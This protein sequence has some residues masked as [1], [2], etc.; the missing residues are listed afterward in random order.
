[1]KAIYGRHE[2][3][4]YITSETTKFYRSD[5]AEGDMTLKKKYRVGGMSK[6]QGIN[7]DHNNKA[8]PR[9]PHKDQKLGERR[10]LVMTDAYRGTTRIMTASQFEATEW[11][12]NIEE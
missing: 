6:K 8:R 10:V 11:G 4:N 12:W 7:G 5:P 9:V 3:Q 2:G 1:M